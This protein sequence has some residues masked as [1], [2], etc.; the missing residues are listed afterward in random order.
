MLTIE[1]ALNDQGCISLQIV[2][3]KTKIC[4]TC[5][6]EKR[7][8]D[9]SKYHKTS[10]GLQ[11]ECKACNS[12]T[13]MLYRK[14]LNGVLRGLFQHAKS[15]SKARAKNGRTDVGADELEFS[16]LEHLWNQQN[17]V[18][19]YSNL[20]MNYN[21]NEWK[22]SL[23]R[24]NPKIGYIKGNIALI[25]LELNHSS[26]WSF[27]KINEM[28][29]ILDKNIDES[30]VSFDINMDKDKKNRTKIIKQVINGEDYYNCTYCNL[31]KHVDE[32]PSRINNGCIDCSK[33]LQKQFLETPRG[34]LLSLIN[35]GKWNSKIRAKVGN[36]NRESSM[37]ID[38]EFLVN[39]YNE[40][41]G[42]CAYSKIPL[43]FG[44]YLDKNW[45]ISLERIDVSKGYMKDNVCLICYEF[46]TMDSS[47][48]YKNNE[49][50]GNSGWTREKFNVF[51]NSVKMRNHK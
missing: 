1:F 13:K 16:D 19:F 41:K 45:T 9:F 23:E 49:D 26:N 18:C 4:P 39:L 44:S 47:L 43:Q 29:T 7:H 37:D 31:I 6:T 11:H 25:C 22:I 20:P 32:F 8:E 46:N 2:I 3:H 14:S 30:F 48:V 36:I 33:I 50:T 38:F 34:K 40:Q 27:D 42:L 10:D 51:L 12:N 35:S 21:R 24:I 15:N 28:V 17:G 5:H